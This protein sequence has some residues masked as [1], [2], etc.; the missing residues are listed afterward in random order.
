[1]VFAYM[2]NHTFLKVAPRDTSKLL[3]M[4]GIC[5]DGSVTNR[6]GS[7]FGPRGI[8]TASHMLCDG[9][10]PHF[11]TTPSGVLTDMG[12]F[13][14]PNTSLTEM[15]AKL[16]PQV[17]PLL[18][19]YHMIWLGGDHSITFPLLQCY[20]EVLKRPLAVLHFDAHCDTW[21]SH[22]D[23]PRV[24]SAQEYVN[25][26]GGRTFTARDLRGLESPLQLE[27]TIADVCSRLASHGNPPVYISFDID[28]LDPAFAPG[29]GT[30]EP[31]GLS[32]SQALTLME[33]FV[34]RVPNLVGMDLVEVAPAYDHAELTT[35]AASSIVWTYMCG[36]IAASPEMQ[37]L[38]DPP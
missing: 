35:N 26:Q 20:H 6:P 30:P 10:H 37:L 9:Y 19:K 4:A 16:K 13:N 2:S 8:R 33:E 24:K 31:G 15:R 12:D 17:I 32:S 18:N 11:G 29:T 22:F 14:L 5:W 1:M 21:T 3:A 38:Q 34:S 7:R 25:E 36:I 27:E 23:E 28:C